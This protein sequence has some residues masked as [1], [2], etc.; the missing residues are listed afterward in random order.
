MGLVTGMKAMLFLIPVVFA[1]GLFFLAGCASQPAGER[2]RIIIEQDSTGV[3]EEAAGAPRSMPTPETRLRDSMKSLD[4]LVHPAR[5]HRLSGEAPEVEVRPIDVN[6]LSRGLAPLLGTEEP[7]LRERLAS[8]QYKLSDIAL[9]HLLS[10]QSGRS[11]ED[12]LRNQPTGSWLDTLRQ[13][14]ISVEQAIEHLDHIYAETAF[15]RLD[16]FE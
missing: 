4:S 12:F 10:Q 5:I 13:A 2:S 14:G 15:L 16:Q 9:S 8:R 7:F 3:M 6:A 1:G 11:M